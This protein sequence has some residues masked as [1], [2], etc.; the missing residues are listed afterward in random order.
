MNFDMTPPGRGF[1]TSLGFLTGGEDHWTSQINVQGCGKVTDLTFG[2]AAN[3]S[4]ERADR[5]NGTYTGLIFARRAVQIIRD[6]PK[7]APLFL[8]CAL[9]NTHAPIESPTAYAGLYHYNDTRRDNYYGQVSFVD[10][11]VRNITDALKSSGL[12]EN[13]WFIWTTDNGSPVNSAGSNAPLKGGKGS[14]WDGGYRVPGFIGGGLLPAARR[15]GLLQSLFHV[16]DWWPT[17]ASL[18]GLD[19]VD[20]FGPTPVDGVDQSAAI[21]SGSASP[22]RTEAV[23][24]HL[25]HCVP[26]PG[27]DASQCVRGQ[28]PDFPAG[29]YPNHTTGALLTVDGGKIY[30]LVVGPAQQATWYGHWPRNSTVPPYPKFVDCWPNPC[31]YDLTADPTEHRNLASV[32]PAMLKQMLLRFGDLASTYHPPKRNPP[33]DAVGVCAA[34]KANAGFLQ[35]WKH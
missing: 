22:P 35:P 32:E 17:F 26:G 23:L 21:L 19:A 28:T 3:R 15:G 34:V 1:D 6:H 25:M 31:L 18:A 8:Y 20:D 27:Y 11:T 14:L 24:D 4:I 7:T 33:S 9:H 10:D 5:L 30:K 13:T 29:H 12:W 2:F 16:S